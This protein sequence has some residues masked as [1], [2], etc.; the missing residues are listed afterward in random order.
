[1]DG[2]RDDGSN[3]A[4]GRQR[5]V[6]PGTVDESSNGWYGDD[7]FHDGMAKDEIVDSRGLYG[8]ELSIGDWEAS[9]CAAFRLQGP[10]IVISILRAFRVDHW[11]MCRNMSMYLGKAAARLQLPVHLSLGRMG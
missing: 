1:M 11:L 3:D 2:G 6:R 9:E 5:L 10:R 7:G 4:E 8:D